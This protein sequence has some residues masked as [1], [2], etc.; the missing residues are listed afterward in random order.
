LLSHSDSSRMC[1]TAMMVPVG[2]NMPLNT[3]PIPAHSHI[4]RRCAQLP[5]CELPRTHQVI[6]KLRL[7]LQPT[8]LPIDQDRPQT[9]QHRLG[10]HAPD[11]ELHLPLITRQI[12]GRRQHLQ[13]RGVVANI[14]QP[15]AIEHRLTF[16][17]TPPPCTGN[18]CNTTR[19]TPARWCS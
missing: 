1:F 15:P 6:G 5:Q 4:L 14:L 13:I 8:L 12:H 19:C 11:N 10:R 18:R 7:H 2:F 16:H 17:K 9:H 3:D